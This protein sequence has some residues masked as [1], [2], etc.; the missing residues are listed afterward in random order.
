M[1]EQLEVPCQTEHFLFLQKF[2][3]KVDRRVAGSCSLL[4][5]NS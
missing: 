2:T 3:E 4:G 5:G 1:S